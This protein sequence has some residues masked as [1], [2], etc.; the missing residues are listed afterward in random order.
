LLLLFFVFT[1]VLCYF[2]HKKMAVRVSRT[3]HVASLPFCSF[4]PADHR[5]PQQGPPTA[6]LTTKKGSMPAGK[7]A[8]SPDRS[9][10]DIDLP[11]G[12]RPADENWR[13]LSIWTFPST[14]DPMPP[15]SL[16]RGSQNA[17][18]VACCTGCACRHFQPRLK[19]ATAK[20]QPNC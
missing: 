10:L 11:P 17:S 14:A 13:E 18:P 7:S 6:M 16:V 4:D 2:I 5:L 9:V 3:P 1:M 8:F 12:Y 15:E 20:C 19:S